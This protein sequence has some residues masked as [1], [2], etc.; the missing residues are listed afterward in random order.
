M[1]YK[2]CVSGVDFYKIQR[3]ALIRVVS[4]YFYNSLDS[5]NQNGTFATKYILCKFFHLLSL[6]N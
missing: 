5:V 3:W 4:K 1:H 6:I 2:V